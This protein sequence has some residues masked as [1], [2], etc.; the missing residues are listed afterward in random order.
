MALIKHAAVHNELIRSHSISTSSL[1]AIGTHSSLNHPIHPIIPILPFHT[2]P[3]LFLPN[4]PTCHPAAGKKTGNPFNPYAPMW[5]S[6]KIKSNLS[7]SAGNTGQ[8]CL[9]LRSMFGSMEGHR[10]LMWRVIVRSSLGRFWTIS[11]G[12]RGVFWL[13]VSLA[14]NLVHVMKEG[15]KEGNNHK[16]LVVGADFRSLC[17]GKASPTCHET[18]S[19]RRSDKRSIILSQLHHRSTVTKGE[20]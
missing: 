11:Q 9:N 20:P 19:S 5:A 17:E 15:G 13:P 7:I 18:M 8:E 6:P 3:I 12:L 16:R 10:T 4:C 14:L 2:L 1:C